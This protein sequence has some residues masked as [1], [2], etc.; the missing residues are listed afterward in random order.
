MSDFCTLVIVQINQSEQNS[1]EQL[2]FLAFR[3]GGGGGVYSPLMN[4]QCN[5]LECIC[6]RSKSVFLNEFI[7]YQ[8][9]CY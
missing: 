5:T 2:H 1:I 3:E 8:V 9:V 7:S 4:V 6:P